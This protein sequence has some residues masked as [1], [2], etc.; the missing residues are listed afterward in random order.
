MATYKRGWSL[1]Q[2]TKVMD[3]YPGPLKK[4]KQ[5]KTSLSCDYHVVSSK[6]ASAG[7][8]ATEVPQVTNTIVSQC[9]NTRRVSICDPLYEKGPFVI[10]HQH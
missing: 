8:D 6:P 3:S 7:R 10:F 1:A 5:F 2:Q 4:G 9:G